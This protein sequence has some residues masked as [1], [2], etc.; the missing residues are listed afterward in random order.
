MFRTLQSLRA[1]IRSTR[2][3]PC[4]RKM[5]TRES[6]AS[7]AADTTKITDKLDPKLILYGN[8]L[9]R[10]A[11]NMALFALGYMVVTRHQNERE[12]NKETREARSE[13]RATLTEKREIEQERRDMR[14]ND[15]EQER[16]RREIERAECERETQQ[17]ERNRQVRERAREM[18][19]LLKEERI[20]NQHSRELEQ[21]ASR[22]LSDLRSLNA[23]DSPDTTS[24]TK[25]Q[26]NSQNLPSIEELRAQLI[27]EIQVSQ[28]ERAKR[29]RAVDQMEFDAAVPLQKDDQDP[30]KTRAADLKMKKELKDLRDQADYYYYKRP[31]AGQASGNDPLKHGQSKLP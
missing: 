15:R 21:Q 23:Y 6:Q 25:A 5:S 10:L 27:N 20:K 19:E 26:A 31:K 14:R 24:R 30:G 3:K 29:E 22:Y 4:G 17:L 13:E 11:S 18:R 7:T 1:A 28:Q 12:S 16:E 2:T 8:M 9:P